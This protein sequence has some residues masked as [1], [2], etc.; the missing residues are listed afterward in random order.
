MIDGPALANKC[1]MDR[2]HYRTD[3][4]LFYNYDG[5]I[6]QGIQRSAA[7]INWMLTIY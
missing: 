1:N 5:R 7:K 4:R 3:E 2:I 6:E